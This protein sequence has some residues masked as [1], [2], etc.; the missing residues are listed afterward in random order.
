MKKHLLYFAALFFICNILFVTELKAQRTME[1]LSR[2]VVAQK[3][4]TGMFV[5]WRITSD[6]WYNTSYKLY[7]DGNLIHET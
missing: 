4:P 3:L 7:R 5:N 2:S 1:K 6:E